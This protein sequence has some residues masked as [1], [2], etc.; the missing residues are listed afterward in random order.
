MNISAQSQTSF[1][2]L[3][4]LTLLPAGGYGAQPSGTAHGA[5]CKN[6]LPDW[7]FCADFELGDL[8]RWDHYPPLNDGSPVIIRDPTAIDSHNHVL[9]LRVRPGYKGS[10][11]NKTFTPSQYQRLYARWY[12]LYEPGFDFSAKNHGHGFHAGERWKRGISGK[13]PK[14]DDY[15]TVQLEYK[16]AKNQQP[17]RSYIYSYFRGMDMDCQDPNGK[18]WGDHFPCMISDRYCR[19]P[20]RKPHTLPPALQENRWYCMELMVDAGTPVQDPRHADGHLNFWVNGVPYGPWNNLWFRTDAA[21][22]VNHFWLGLY[23]HGRHSEEGILY[24]NIVISRSRVGCD[25]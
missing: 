11:L 8:Q 22:L 2:V 24:D 14:G 4:L 21:V 19:R 17:P 10:G 16:P 1:W 20:E 3:I 9:Q 5:T 6:P 12:Q 25:R 7:I 18:C 23:H 13:R 15:F